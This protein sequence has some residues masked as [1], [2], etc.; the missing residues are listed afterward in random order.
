MKIE[1]YFFFA[2]ENKQMF[3]IILPLKT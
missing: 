3:L 2:N 1:I